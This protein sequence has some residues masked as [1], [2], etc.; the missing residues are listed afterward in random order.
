MQK[1]NQ[2]LHQKINAI[3]DKHPENEDEREKD[4]PHDSENGGKTK[5]IKILSIIILVMMQFL[6]RRN[7]QKH[8]LLQATLVSL[9][10][11]S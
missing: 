6:K 4:I 7:P 8:Q 10:W 3:P 5:L 2:E 11:S 9:K 1:E